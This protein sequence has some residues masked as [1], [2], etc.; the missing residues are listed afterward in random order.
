MVHTINRAIR[1]EEYGPASVLKVTTLPKP[2]PQ[3]NQVLVKIAYAGINFGDA[4]Q[5][6]GIYPLPLPF[7]AGGEGSGVIVELGPGVEHGFKVGDRVAFLALG[8]YTDYVVVNTD[9]LVKLPSHISLEQGAAYLCQGL[10]AVALA[11]KAYSIQ[12]GDWIAIY[13]AAGGVGLLLTQI[14]HHRGA[15]VIGI[16]ST[17]EKAEL[18]R[19]NGADEVVV[20]P[21]KDYT[22]L[23]KKVQELTLGLGVHAV[24]DS[25]GQAT[26]ESTLNIARRLGAIILYG[27][28][29]GD[30]PPQPLGRF[31]AKNLKLMW[32]TVLQYITTYDELNALFQRAVALLDEGVLNVHVSKVYKLEEAQQAHLDLEAR[33]TT[34]KLLI[35]M[36]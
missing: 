26:F 27:S 34:G 15:H 33:R 9:R 29:S 31:A 30:I 11:E 1:V 19:S 2:V 17:P 32:M 22:P 24:Y 20:I 4:G 25:V 36:D 3:T 7:T 21:G 12:K 8:T 6:S 28:T 23:E 10:T 16:V 13:A 35:K 18:V 14:A 5:R